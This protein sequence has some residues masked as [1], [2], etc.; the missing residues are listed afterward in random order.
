MH[1]ARFVDIVARL[2]DLACGARCAGCGGRGVPTPCASCRHAL[3]AL[4]SPAGA[5]WPDVGVARTL[6]H[7]A[8]FGHWR[9]GGRL[10]AVLA[11][12]RTPDAAIDLVT[13]VPGEPSRR[14]RRG[15][16]LPESLARTW[17]R[18]RHVPCRRL[19]RRRRGPS[20]QGLDRAQRRRNV[21]DA[22]TFASN[23]DVDSLAGCRILLVDDVRTTGATLAATARILERVGAVV[24]TFALVERGAP[25]GSRPS[26]V[27]QRTGTTSGN[28]ARCEEF[29]LTTVGF[30]A[31]SV[32]HERRKDAP[33]V[34]KP[35]PP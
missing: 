16:H 4:Q 30:P 29:V 26:G 21:A 6:T 5:A 13:W 7:A 22:W 9:G 14:A 20:Q 10:L 8:K 25:N 24:E 33:R 32:W 1:R 17:A 2:V 35:R 28:P 3:N 15:G 19:L 12:E 31:D 27:G 34:R 11:C 23:V 18:E